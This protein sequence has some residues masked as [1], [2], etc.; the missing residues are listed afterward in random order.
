[1]KMKWNEV[2]CAME[3]E[4]QHSLVPMHC[5]YQEYNILDIY[6]VPAVVQGLP[7]AHIITPFC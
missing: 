1:M 4:W 7:S 5:I 2:I 6:N 3:T